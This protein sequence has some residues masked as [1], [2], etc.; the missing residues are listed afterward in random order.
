MREQRY[1]RSAAIALLGVFIGVS[2]TITVA[3]A[4]SRALGIFE[5]QSD[6]GALAVPGTGTYDAAAGTYTVSAAGANIWATADA[7]HF[8]WKKVSGDVSLTADIDFPVKTANAPPHRKAVLMLRQDLTPDSAYAD[9]AFHGSGM[10]AL[11]FRHIKGGISQ[12]IELNTTS[13]SRFRIERRGDI[14]TLFVSISGEPLHQVGSSTR[15]RL[16]DDFY[17]GLG[18]CAHNAN[19]PEKAVFSKVESKS[20]TPPASATTTLYSSLQTVPID[21]GSR[22]GSMVYTMQGRFEAPNWS[23]DGKALVFDQDGKIMTVAATGGTPRALDIGEASHCNGSH[24]FSPDGEWLAISC[25]MPGKPESRVYIVPA[26]GGTPRIVTEGANSY[27][28]SWSPDG[29]TIFFTHPDNGSINIYSIPVKGGEAKALTSG[30]GISDDPDSSPDGKFVYFH[31]DRSGSVQIWRMHPDGS[32]TEQVTEDDLMNRTPHISPD[33]KSMVALSYG[34]EVSGRLVNKPVILRVM[35]L[36]GSKRI[37]TIAEFI[38]GSG[39]MNV[40]SWAPD[41]QHLAFVS[42]QE[43]PADDGNIH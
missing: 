7:F 35:S 2:P 3:Q 26:N 10:T 1:L 30:N 23:R 43:L 38:G 4:T 33:G 16:S 18:V 29:N 24:G 31:S 40:P 25:G 41:S 21:P 8:L 20:L 32:N 15:V 42:Y 22:R 17:L 19:V 39:T 6:I 14:I 34:K 28:H 9:A 27:W 13:A 11:Q 37:W 5:G 12:D 36:D